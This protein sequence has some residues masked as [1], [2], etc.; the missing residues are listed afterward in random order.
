M[1]TIHTIDDGRTPGFVRLACGAITP[2]SGMLLK[3]TDGKLAV[4]TGADE[5]AYISVTDRETACAD[6]E[7]ITVT[8][9]GPDMTLVAE[10]PEEFTGKTGDKVQIGDD[11][12]TITGTAGGA[13]EIVTT[14]EERT[15]FR[16]VP[17]K[18][19]A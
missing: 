15:T 6:G 2:K 16:L 4:A 1:I 8:R 17:V 19:T 7:E 14:D 5:P 3:V 10:T 9:I 11:G 13:C 18:A 12:M